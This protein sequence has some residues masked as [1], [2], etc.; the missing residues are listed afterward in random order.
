[1]VSSKKY[2]DNPYLNNSLSPSEFFNER[3]KSDKM[4]PKEVGQ[5]QPISFWEKNSRYYG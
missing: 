2:S 1:M 5:P 3:A 4:Y